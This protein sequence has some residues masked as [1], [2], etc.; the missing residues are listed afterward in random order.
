MKFTLI[1]KAIN[2]FVSFF[3][4]CPTVGD[5]ISTNV[6]YKFKTLEFVYVKF[7]FYNYC[8]LNIVNIVNYSSVNIFCIVNNV[9]L[10]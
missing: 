6:L 4:E 8:T 7:F 2:V 3:Y 9:C 5:W 10:A 1:E